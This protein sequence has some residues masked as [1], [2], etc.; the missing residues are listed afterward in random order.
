MTPFDSIMNCFFSA[1]KRKFDGLHHSQGETKRRF[2]NHLL[3][4]TW[5]H[6]PLPQQP[7]ESSNPDQ[8][9]ADSFA[10]WQ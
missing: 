4:N 9:Y 5:G 6:N 8:W 10:P 1:G 2:A 3:P 7:L